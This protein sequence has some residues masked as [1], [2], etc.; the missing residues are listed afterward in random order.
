MFY[1][2]QQMAN[3]AC[4]AQFSLSLKSIVISSE[5]ER[6]LTKPT[7]HVLFRV[8]RPDISGSQISWATCH[9]VET[10]VWSKEMESRW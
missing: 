10:V 6:F 3:K 2:Y 7:N 8:V 1:F 4:N 5:H 9:S